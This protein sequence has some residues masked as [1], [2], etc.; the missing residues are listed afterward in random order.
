MAL[1]RRFFTNLAADYRAARPPHADE[2][3]NAV[4]TKMVVLT[5]NALAV[6]NAMFNHQR[7]YEAC[8]MPAENIQREAG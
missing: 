2:Q 8:G 7:F 6:Q 3:A 4:W 5:A 1:T